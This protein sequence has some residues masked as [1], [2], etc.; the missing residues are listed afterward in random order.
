M[1]QLY[2]VGGSGHYDYIS[3]NQTIVQVTGDG[4]LL[5]QNKGRCVINF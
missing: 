5:S 4:V 2:I 3:R 1:F